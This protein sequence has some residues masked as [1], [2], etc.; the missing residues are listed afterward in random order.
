MDEQGITDETM[1][2]A[3]YAISYLQAIGR[4]SENFLSS[5]FVTGSEILSYTVHDFMQFIYVLYKEG[6]NVDTSAFIKKVIIQC[7][8]KIAN[9]RPS[10]M[11]TTINAIFRKYPRC[12]S[13]FKNFIVESNLSLEKKAGVLSSI[14]FINMQSTS[15]GVHVQ[16]GQF[17]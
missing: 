17:S 16:I 13:D 14:E 11:L 6:G 7:I 8:E 9:E 12:L 15:R 10:W 5:N 4:A 2:A 3:P 1:P